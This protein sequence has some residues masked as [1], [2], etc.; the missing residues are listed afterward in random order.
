MKGWRIYIVLVII[1]FVGAAIISRLFFLQVI[2]R[3]FY[4]AQ[5]LGQ[6]SGFENTQGPRGEIFC[7][8]SQQDKGQ[9]GSGQLKSL[10]INEDNWIVS[11]KPKEILDKEVF[12]EQVSNIL[13]EKKEDVFLKINSES[14]Y[15][16]LQKKVSSEVL[17]K[18]KA[19]NIKGI[20]WEQNTDRYYPQEK[21]AAHV[22][23][24]MGG[25]DIGQYGI[26][27][28]YEDILKGKSGILESKKGLDSFLS[29]E[30]EWSLNGSDIYL[31]IDYNIQFE[32]EMLLNE[33]KDKLDI[34]SGQIIVLKPDSGRV[35]ALANYPS[36]NSNQYSKEKDIATFKNSA[37][38]K[39]FEPGS[40]MKPFTVAI[41]LNEG[42]ITPETKYVDE[43]FINIGPDKISNFD[44]QKYGER[45]ISG[46]LEK[47]INT[48]AVFVSQQVSHKTFFDYLDKFGFTRKTDIDLQGEAYSSNESL[49]NGHDMEYA[50]AS[51]GQAISMT[52][53]QIARAFCTF[54]NGG[55]LV[56]PHMV[57]KIINGNDE[58]DV[59]TEVEDQVISPETA[60]KVTIMM[61]NVIERGFGL[62]GR[63]P[64]Y[65]IA[66]KTGTAEVPL[67]NG[68]GYET[69]KTIQSF[70][71]FGPTKDPQFLILV[72]LD[73]P[74]V[75]KSSLSAAP[76]FKKLAQY[77]INYW[78]IPPDYDVNKK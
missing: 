64:G 7:Q 9:K 37:V 3:K 77:I 13:S 36:F 72:K 53:I 62:E 45:D 78:Q 11:V 6:Q 26:E 18:I 39:I 14:S 22:L 49:R 35:I 65:Y 12:S 57:E 1:L 40:I 46:I 15:V 48:G 66:G 51:F 76:V 67:K 69:N 10:A 33:V 30:S 54:A 4:Q 74:K 50:T 28:Y 32:A 25:N 58:L 17:D 41:A 19:L 27:G 59:K 68:R 5:A 44:K 20:Y 16:V 73:D 38:Q 21:L 52:P 34:E 24:F 2:N 71:G 42:K 31:T 60:S 75:P 8:N 29:N 47:S 43:G 55:K 70:I 56:K 63:V 23:G 61:T